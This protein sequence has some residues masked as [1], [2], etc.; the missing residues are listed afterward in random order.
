MG[1]ECHL[2]ASILSDEGGRG[3][4]LLPNFQKK[5]GG[6]GGG[7]AWKELKFERGVAGKEGCNFSL[8]GGG[9][10]CNFTKQKTKKKQKSEIF[11]DQRKNYKQNYFSLS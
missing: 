4:N 7:G 11:N 6:R 8:D 10:G 5:I 1:F 3:L 2:G 9:G